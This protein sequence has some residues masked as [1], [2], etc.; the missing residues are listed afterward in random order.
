MYKCFNCNTEWTGEKKVSF[1]AICEKCG[2]YIHCC[3]NCKFFDE[4][5]HNKCRIPGTDMV[6]DREKGNYCEEFDFGLKKDD[7][8]LEK[9]KDEARK[10][11]DDLFK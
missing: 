4:T 2:A 1:K 6:A 5:Q 10:K 7:S 8:Y 11:L 9:K 3:K